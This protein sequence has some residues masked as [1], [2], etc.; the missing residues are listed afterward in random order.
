MPLLQIK[1]LSSPSYDDLSCQGRIAGLER[2]VQGFINQSLTFEPST[3]FHV[4]RGHALFAN[5][6][7]QLAVQQFLEKVVVAKPLR[8]ECWQIQNR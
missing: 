5:L 6:L 2:M 8:R 4:E 1:E 7:D 3:G